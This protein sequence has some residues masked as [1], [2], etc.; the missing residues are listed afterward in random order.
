MGVG[1]GAGEGE[2]V[3]DGEAV[4]EAV[5]VGLDVGRRTVAEAQAARN[6][7]N[8]SPVARRK[9]RRVHR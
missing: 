9:R 5:G 1:V 8:P 2:A 4:G 6:A 3:G 7:T